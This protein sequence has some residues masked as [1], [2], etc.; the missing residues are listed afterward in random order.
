MMDGSFEVQ[1]HGGDGSK[2]DEEGGSP[3]AA[4]QGAGT[5]PAPISVQTARTHV[6]CQPVEAG[7]ARLESLQATAE[8]QLVFYSLFAK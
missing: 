3:L 8:Y 4:W 7:R 6:P 1:R 2:G 5:L